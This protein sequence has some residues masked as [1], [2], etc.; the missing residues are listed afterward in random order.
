MRAGDQ[1]R[2]RGAFPLESLANGLVQQVPGVD[3][4]QHNR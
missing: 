2:H 4:L 1:D 3:A